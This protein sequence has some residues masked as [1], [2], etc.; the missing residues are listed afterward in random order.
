MD[1]KA[2]PKAAKK[3]V[4]QKEAK[5]HHVSTAE[6][7]KKT[8]TVIQKAFH[9]AKKEVLEEHKD[10]VKL[11]DK[12][13]NSAKIAA[14]VEQAMFDLYA[15]AN[16]RSYR[17]HCRDLI[18]NLTD[19]AN[20][21]LRYNAETGK[22]TGRA[23]AKMTYQDMAAEELKK[24][25]KERSSKLG[26]HT[27][28]AHVDLLEY[29]TKSTEHECFRCG[30]H[31]TTVYHLR[32]HSLGFDHAATASKDEPDAMKLVKCDKCPHSWKKEV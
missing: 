12:L 14:A 17:A 13:A 3:F 26:G 20:V 30:S 1:F 32:E 24:E 8:V 6:I 27:L 22:L 21:T 11:K 7:R 18:F 10:E 25:R 5:T 28:S 29:G 2:K 31:V 23:L 16:L 4:A 9:T 19:P 15:D